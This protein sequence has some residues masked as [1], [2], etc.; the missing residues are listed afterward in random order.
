MYICVIFNICVFLRVKKEK[1]KKRDSFKGKDKKVLITL[2]SLL[3]LSHFPYGA[4]AHPFPFVF[5]FLYYTGFP[6]NGRLRN[7]NLH[8]DQNPTTLAAGHYISPNAVTSIKIVQGL[9]N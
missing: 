2:W 8:A 7:G 4:R 9:S 3:E 1:K 5:F 6:N